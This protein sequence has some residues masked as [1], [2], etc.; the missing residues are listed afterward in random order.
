MPR[1]KDITGQRFGKLVALEYVG[2]DKHNK[3]LWR[4]K[5]DCG[6]E[7]ITRSNNLQQGDTQSCGCLHERR[8]QGQRFGRLQVLERAG[9]NNSRHN[10]WRCKCDC[11]NITEVSA[12][13]LLLGHTQSCG[14]LMRET[15]SDMFS[16]HRESK[17][18]LYTVWS[19]M[20]NKCEHPSHKSYHNYG[21]RGIKVCEEWRNSYEAFRDWAL[22]NGY[23]ENAPRGQC[24]IDRI[25]NDGDYEPSNCRWVDSYTQAHNQRPRRKGYKRKMSLKGDA[26]EV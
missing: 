12:D 25:D 2:K 7:I 8:L 1:F 3:I 24:T 4:C 22:A 9:T 19:G 23:D 20:K 18:R 21:G 17:S 10:K 14:C 5:C 26:N 6:G 11:G 16:T 15:V 13:L